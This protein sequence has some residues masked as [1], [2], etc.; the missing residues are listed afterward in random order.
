MDGRYYWLKLKKDFF[1]RH[2]IRILESM[3][4]GH[5]T[6][7]F[8]LKLMLES[9]DHEGELRFSE[10]TAY[11]PEMLATITDTDIEIVKTSLD[12]LGEFGLVEITSDGTIVIDKV[13]SMVGF[14]TK[15]AEK[16]RAWREQQSGR[17]EDNVLDMSSECPNSVLTLSDKSKSKSKSKRQSKRQSKNIYIFVPPSV[18]EVYEY[19][20]SRHNTIN[21]QLFVDYYQSKNWQISNGCQ[22]TDWKAAVRSWENNSINYKKGQE[23]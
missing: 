19:C 14:E 6:V 16:K 12:R 9:V 1:K 20:E 13:K 10:K 17:S 8:Y 18:D 3:P 15:W 21:A 11:S 5:L 2:D 22:M 7:L 23:A 4:D